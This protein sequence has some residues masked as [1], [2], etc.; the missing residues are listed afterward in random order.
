MSTLQKTASV[1][2]DFFSLDFLKNSGTGC[3]ASV[4]IVSITHVYNW[5]V[6][7]FIVG[8]PEEMF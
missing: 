8:A 1:T 2:F 7:G 4:C 6:V 5:V 3:R